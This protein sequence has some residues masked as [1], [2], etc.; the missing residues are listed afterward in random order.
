MWIVNVKKQSDNYAHVWLSEARRLSNGAMISTGRQT[1]KFSFDLLRG[2]FDKLSE[3]LERSIGILVAESIVAADDETLLIAAEMAELLQGAIQ[4][5][6]E[7]TGGE[8]SGQV[9]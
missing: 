2:S 1:P 7:N 9:G 4:E 3:R 5:A 6:E 8:A